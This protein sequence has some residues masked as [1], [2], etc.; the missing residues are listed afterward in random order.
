MKTEKPD[1]PASLAA[2][3]LE[4][5]REAFV[6]RRRSRI[7]VESWMNQQAAQGSLRTNS[8]APAWPDYEKAA[9]EF[10]RL[11]TQILGE[12]AELKR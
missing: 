7:E 11:I 6:E 1:T 9:L 8:Q 4:L 2:E 12:P 3:P 10:D 5:L